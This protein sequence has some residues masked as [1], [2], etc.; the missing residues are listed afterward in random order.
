MDTV[1]KK[2]MFFVVAATAGVLS[3][4]FTAILNRS[5]SPKILATLIF[6]LSLFILGENTLRA[7]TVEYKLTIAQETVSFTGKERPAM[8]INGNIP[9]PTLRFH[10]GDSAVIHVHNAMNVNTSIHWH[11][12]L[13]PNGQDGVPYLTYPPI[14]PGSTFTYR[15]M[16]RHAGTYWYHSHSGLQE[17]QGIY[18]SIAIETENRIYEEVRDE[19]VLLSDWSDENPHEI[20]RKL[21]RGSEWYAVKKNSAQSVLGAYRAGKVGS[22][23]QR[24]LSRMPA[25]DISDVAYDRFLANGKSSYK[26]HASPGETLRLRIINGSAT[27]YFLLEFAGGPMKIIAA[28]GI[29]VRPFEEQRFLIGVAETYDVLIRVPQNGSYELRATA[30]DGSGHASVWI[31]EG[32]PNAA[33]DIPKPD[34]YAAM[35]EVTLRSLFALTPEGSMGMTTGDVE[36]GKFDRPGMNMQGHS[37]VAM[38]HGKM[39]MGMPMSHKNQTGHNISMPVDEMAHDPD[40]MPMPMAH[41]STD[42]GTKDQDEGTGRKSPE[43]MHDGHQM[44]AVETVVDG[45][46]PRR[47][48]PIYE[49]LRALEPTVFPPEQSRQV[50]RL[51]L[52]GDMD[53]Y[54]WYFNNKALHE[55][56]KV[57]IRKGQVARFVMINRTMMHHPIH[58][59]GHFFRVINGQGDYSPL[60]HTVNVAPMSTSVI[61]FDANDAG[62]WFFH[63]HLLYHMHSGMARILHYESFKPDAEVSSIRH[64]LLEDPIYFWGEATAM[65]HMTE[66]SLVLSNT[67]NILT[68][69][70]Q[71]GWQDVEDTDYEIDL[72]WDYS[73]NRYASVFAGA[74]ITNEE[75]GDRGIFGGRYL[76]PLL[77]QT[78]GWVDTEG[79]LRLSLSKELPLTSRL[80]AFGE[81]EYDTATKWECQ[82]GAIFLIDKRFSIMASYHTEFGIGAGLVIRF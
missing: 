31:G 32:E 10:V 44:G 70:W 46:D 7:D 33:P 54:V 64:K 58:L 53:R 37:G 47:P 63:C 24:E 18:G 60:K 57:T 79:E 15:F 72:T 55:Q 76:L 25:M 74:E 35:G 29:D 39:P 82:A 80:S 26:I 62:D 28:D 6:L 12:I 42:H 71:A 49:K 30:H 65:S 3:L 52:D 45:K 5:R 68:A 16:I 19:V 20:M 1:D 75:L 51:T 66:G 21:K 56:D 48:W 17:Q 41:Q 59:H 13:L 67:R 73:F 34:L 81:I 27:T 38:N 69:D 40:L 77:I 43:N 9:G 8:T 2:W 61:E 23:F 14:A 50:I 78:T 11:G 22:F 4:L 36:A